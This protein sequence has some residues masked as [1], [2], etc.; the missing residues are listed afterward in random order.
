MPF[1]ADSVPAQL[2]ALR[3]RHV[4]LTE[5][6]SDLQTGFTSLREGQVT[7]AAQL[8]ANTKITSDIKDIL[9]AGRV[10]RKVAVWVTAIAVAIT[11]VWATISSFVHSL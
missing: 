6:L 4:V 3:I 2:D 11:S 5:R 1:D 8:D 7:M 9:V 10:T